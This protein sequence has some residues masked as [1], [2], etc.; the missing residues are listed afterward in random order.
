E[1]AAEQHDTAQIS[2][3]ECSAVRPEVEAPDHGVVERARIREDALEA[4]EVVDLLHP[5]M[6]WGRRPSRKLLVTSRAG[7]IGLPPMSLHPA[8]V[9]A[10][11]LVVIILGAE[12]LLRGASRI[13][14]MLG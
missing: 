7:A 10:G 11:G 1:H 2:R 8:I 13:A 14:A 12:L 5:S 9:F 4:G 6:L 3:G